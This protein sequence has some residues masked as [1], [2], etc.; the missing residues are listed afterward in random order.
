MSYCQSCGNEVN[1]QATICSK[2]GSEIQKVIQPTKQPTTDPLTKPIEDKVK[3]GFILLTV[4][5]PLFG[6][7]YGLVIRKT[8]PKASNIYIT[9][10]GITALLS[11]HASTVLERILTRL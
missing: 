10:W 6:L 8:R 9:I 11:Y 1:E 2:C 5:I 7:I 4:F 3:I